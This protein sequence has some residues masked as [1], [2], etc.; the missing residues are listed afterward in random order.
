MV[1]LLRLVLILLVLGGLYLAIVTST[2]FIGTTNNQ[3]IRFKREN[4]NIGRPL[5]A[6]FLVLIIGLQ[7][8][9]NHNVGIGNNTLSVA[10]TM[11]HNLAIG[12]NSLANTVGSNSIAIGS[13]ALPPQ[14]V[15]Q[16]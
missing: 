15:E 10:T 6:Y 13:G 8:T 1:M 2:D 3:D 5:V 16:I 4:V 12:N 9:G 14:Q 11:S 7:V